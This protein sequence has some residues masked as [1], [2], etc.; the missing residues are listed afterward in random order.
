LR[1]TNSW[2]SAFFRLNQASRFSSTGFQPEI[3]LYPRIANGVYAYLNYGYSESVLFPKHRIGAEVFSKLPKSLEASLGFRYLY[4]GPDSKVII[5]TGSFGWY[6][7]NYWLSLRPFITPGNPGT[8]FSSILSLR[9]YF[10]DADNYL[11]IDAGLGFSPDERRIQSG[12]GLSPDDIYVLKTQR[13]GLVCQKTFPHHFIVNV[14]CAFI[15][16]ELLFDQGQY[17]LITSSQV[18]ILKRF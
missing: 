2:G 13:V 6:F 15:N 1:R 14:R 8:S 4:F 18:A 12:A 7:K 10:K 16:Q 11:G 3:D 17:V 9:R 5:Y